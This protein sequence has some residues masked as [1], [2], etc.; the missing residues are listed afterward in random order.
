[1][2]KSIRKNILASARDQFSAYKTLGEKA[3]VQVS[4]EKLHDSPAENLNS[5]AVIMKHLSGNMQSRWTDF[6]T[7]DGEKPW[8]KRENEFHDN[9]TSRSELMRSWNE[10]W[11]KLFTELDALDPEDLTR[12]VYIR[13]ETHTVIEAIH[14][15]LTH[16]AYHVGQIVYLAH[17]Y[18]EN[19]WQYLSIPPGKTEEYNRK[20]S[21]GED[22]GTFSG[23]E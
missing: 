23:K 18:S 10:G 7:A 15:Q 16:Y 20:K 3:I 8:R 6:L 17:L 13:N 5:I 9:F 1:M 14:R 4:D 19:N 12:T 22:P 21:I 2:I 11:S